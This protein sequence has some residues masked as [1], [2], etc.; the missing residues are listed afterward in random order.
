MMAEQP[1]GGYVRQKKAAA[2]L[3]VSVRWFQGHVTV[4]PKTLGVGPGGRPVAV[5]AI[6]DLDAWVELQ[7]P[8]EPTR[9]RA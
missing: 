2:Y 4:R 3:G 1:S 5:Y 7:Q 6:R 8:K 9:R